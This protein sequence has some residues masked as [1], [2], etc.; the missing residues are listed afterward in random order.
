[1]R[2][3]ISANDLGLAFAQKTMES[4]VYQQALCHRQIHLFT[5][6]RDDLTI[7]RISM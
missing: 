1:M 5:A 6:F 7:R 2:V 3:L 4:L